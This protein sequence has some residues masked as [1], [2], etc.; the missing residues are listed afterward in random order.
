MISARRKRVTLRQ[1]DLCSVSAAAHVDTGLLTLLTRFGHLA[2]PFLV[3]CY[4]RGYP[5]GLNVDTSHAYTRVSARC[6]RVA[7]IR[8]CVK[9]IL[10][11]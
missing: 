4:P 1:G 6:R 7:G 3:S 10:L 11:P 9:G 5:R 2:R 8:A